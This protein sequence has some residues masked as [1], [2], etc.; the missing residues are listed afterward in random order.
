MRVANA[1]HESHR[2]RFEEIAPDFRLEDAWAL[3]VEGAADEFPKLLEAMGSLDPAARAPAVVRM[4]FAVRFGVGRLLGWDEAGGTLPIPDA[5]E[6]TLWERLP[7]DL[8]DSAPRSRLRNKSFTP[9]YE[10]ENEWAAEL[11]NRTV[12]G[13]MQLVWVDRG[14]GRYQGQM[15]VYV[16]PRG[17]LGELYMAAIAPF[18]HRIVYPAL[19]DQIGRA[20]NARPAPR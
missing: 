10:T 18:R 11:S 14:D 4:L 19:L 5:T 1:E 17:R 3:P 15:G 20:W 6:M 13:V 7:P 8:R 9:L 12:H 2:W 16:K